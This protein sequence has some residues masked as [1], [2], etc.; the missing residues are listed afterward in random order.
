MKVVIFDFDG[1]LTEKD[2][3]IWRK[4]WRKLGYPTDENSIYSKLYKGFAS[5]LLSHKDWCNQTCRAFQKKNMTTNVLEE[6][7]SEVKL[8]QGATR[9]FDELKNQGY[10]LHIVS[11]NIKQV[12]QKVLGENVK[13]FDSI[14][15]NDFVFDESG[16]LSS[17]NGTK[18]DFEGKA[19]FVE[20]YIAKHNIPISNVVFV[21]N[22]WNDEWVH[23]TGCKTICLTQNSN[24]DYDNKEK[25]HTSVKNIEKL[26]N[27]FKTNGSNS[28][29]EKK[30]GR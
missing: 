20:E 17:V 1:T 11:G 4:I 12:I 14:N 3:N 5:G 9:L 8:K 13:Y 21:G 25:W 16:L 10:S 23:Q 28:Y 26:E 18:Y 27:Y 30:L 19:K 24:V 6:V 22:G 7:A 29:A 15:A 2:G